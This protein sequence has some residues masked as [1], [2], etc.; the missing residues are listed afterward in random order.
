MWCGW[1][2]GAEAPT[3]DCLLCSREWR[4]VTVYHGPPV[5]VLRGP[6]VPVEP[7]IVADFQ[8]LKEGTWLSVVRPEPDEVFSPYRLE[9]RG[10]AVLGFESRRY[11]DD[12]P[13]CDALL[14]P[15]LVAHV[16]AHDVEEDI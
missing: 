12:D 8:P 6:V 2:A 5:V 9:K 10:G 13:L 14:G 11:F 16:V 4:E 15:G 7:D 1:R 3:L